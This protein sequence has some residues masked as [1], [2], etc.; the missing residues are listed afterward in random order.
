[1]MEPLTRLH[2]GIN[3][4]CRY[5][6]E[7]AGRDEWRT[8]AQLFRQGGD[9]EDFA[10]AYWHAVRALLPALEAEVARLDTDPPHMIC[11]V[12]PGPDP[13]VLDVLAD[14]PYRLSE[15]VDRAGIVYAL[16]ADGAIPYCRLPDGTRVRIPEKWAGVLACLGVAA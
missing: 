10:I 8:P 11:T 14:A 9:C 6:P 1:M 5:A 13:W 12:G 2:A 7:P 15:R 4:A 3:A 16:G